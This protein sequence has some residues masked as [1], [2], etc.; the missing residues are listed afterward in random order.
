MEKRYKSLE[1]GLIMKLLKTILAILVA[2]TKSGY[3]RQIER[4]DNE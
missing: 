2:I 1:K 3:V 4:K